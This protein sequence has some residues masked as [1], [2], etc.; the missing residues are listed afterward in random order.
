MGAIVGATA[1]R[2]RH[3]NIVFAGLLGAS[4]AVIAAHLA[5]RLR[6]RLPMSAVA[7]GLLEDA[8][9][10]GMAAVYAARSKR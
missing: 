3:G 1:A 10:M 9:M 6:T 8:V 2:Q 5:F 7:G 4:A